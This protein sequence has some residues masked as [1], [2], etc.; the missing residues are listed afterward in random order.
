MHYVFA[1]LV[2]ALVSTLPSQAAADPAQ[3][4][5][6]GWLEMRTPAV[7]TAPE[8]YVAVRSSRMDPSIGNHTYISVGYQQAWSEDGEWGVQ[9]PLAIT[10]AGSGLHQIFAGGKYRFVDGENFDFSATGYLL[11]PGNV[12]VTE[13]GTGQLGLGAEFEMLIEQSGV[14]LG[15]T[16]GVERADYCMGCP[17]PGITPEGKALRGFDGAVGLRVPIDVHAV[18]AEYHIKW[19][20]KSAAPK[21]DDSDMYAQVGGNIGITDEIST[22]VFLGTGFGFTGARENTKIFGGLT[23]AYAFQ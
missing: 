11:L 3:T 2:V 16:G 10:R 14:Q 22:K 5:L 9:V 7:V 19:S 21:I 12:G 17:R 4:G 15:L 1:L 23:G 6:S 13:T 8:A 18:V 20:N